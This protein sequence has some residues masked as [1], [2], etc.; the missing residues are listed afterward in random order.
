MGNAATPLAPA[1]RVPTPLCR[2]IEA[3]ECGAVA[4]QIMLAWHG[5]HVPLPELRTACRTTR[6]GVKVSGIVRAATAYGLHAQAFKRS[7][8]HNLTPPF[9]IFWRFNHFLV[10]E[11]WTDTIVYVN[12][13][14]AGPRR[15]T[16]AALERDYT[17]IALTFKRL[18]SFQPGGAPT[19]PGRQLWTLLQPYRLLLALLFFVEWLDLLPRL[20]LASA[21][22]LGA[23]VLWN[24][25]ELP[26]L[27]WQL[28]MLAGGSRLLLTLAQHLLLQRL[29]HQEL[30]P[31]F[32]SQLQRLSLA[33]LSARYE[34]ELAQRI[35]M[36]ESILPLTA[37][38]MS[39]AAQMVTWLCSIVIIAVLMSPI[40][41]MMVVIGLGR[42]GLQALIQATPLPHEPAI[43]EYAALLARSHPEAAKLDSS[44][45]AY[46]TRLSD[47]H[48]RA[49]NAFRWHRLHPLTTVWAML[50]GTTLLLSGSPPGWVV[51]VLALG[52]PHFPVYELR[53]TW[54]ALIGM[55]QRIDDLQ[56]APLHQETVA[57]TERGLRLDQMTFSYGESPTLRDINLMIEPG[58]HIALIGASG[59]G[60][61][62]LLRVMAGL[63]VPESGRVSRAPDSRLILLEGDPQAAIHMSLGEW[64]Q[65]QLTAH[66]DAGY[67]IWLLDEATTALD[68]YHEAECLEALRT[69]TVI[70][71]THRLQTLRQCDRI[72]VLQAGQMVEAGTHEAL[73]Q[74]GGVYQRLIQEGIIG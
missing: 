30:T 27:F 13:P 54:Q 65:A 49:V 52:I 73:A 4:L 55:A 44:E 58:E 46:F 16:W 67:S 48:V 51:G 63:Y 69:D 71:V 24:R 37:R 26:T 23:S 25:V 50:H 68:L 28:L 64:Q 40:A 34:D 59:S 11:G 41:L 18:A 38:L 7:T 60:K 29:M 8:F 14:A 33:A 17:G 56:T 6:D 5:R 3:R 15:V 70:L 22:G 36:S 31:A 43:E 1:V 32:V 10:V 47:A 72:V 57:E 35:V 39:Q 74:S 21:L 20:A 42:L 62:T 19:Q 12:D 45:D 2:Q 53:T 61:S 66:M 9:V